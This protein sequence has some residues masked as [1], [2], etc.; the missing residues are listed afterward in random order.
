[1]DK[2]EH[3]KVKELVSPVKYADIAQEVTTILLTGMDIVDCDS[4]LS[5]KEGTDI[6]QEHT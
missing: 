3:R 5:D 4:M 2:L 6:S 1:M